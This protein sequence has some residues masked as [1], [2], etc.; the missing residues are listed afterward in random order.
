M[1]VWH[2][3]VNGYVACYEVTGNESCRLAV[4]NFVDML[5][6]NHSWPTGGSNAAERWGEPMRMGDLLTAVRST[7]ASA[8]FINFYVKQDMCT[9]AI[10]AVTHASQLSPT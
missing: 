1:S 5:I 4:L 7:A 8:L 6:A 9:Y 10:I 2:A 3:Q